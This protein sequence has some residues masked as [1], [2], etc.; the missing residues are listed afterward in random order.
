M[1]PC[2]KRVLTIFL[3]NQPT[4]SIPAHSYLE[5]LKTRGVF[6]GNYFGIRHPSEPNYVAAIAGSTFGIDDDGDYDLNERTLVDLLE[7][8]GITWKAYMEDLPSNQ[9]LIHKSGRYVRK[10]NP[11]ASFTTITAEPA[12]LARIVGADA[13]EADAASGQLPQYCWYTPNLDN[14]G[15]DTGITHASQWLDGFLTPLFAM[16]GFASDT[17]VV[18]TFDER[19]PDDDN[20]VYAVVVG[21]GAIPGRVDDTRYDHYSVL[22]T[23]EENWSLGTLG[24][25]DNNATWF[26]FLWGLPPTV[27]SWEDHNS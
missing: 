26:S 11:F 4:A 21:P 19:H 9:K 14:D 16:P 25:S 7:Q 22:R 6:L 18:V 2:F 15:H 24:R 1:E 20:H 23:V 10:H 27:T 12:R 13:F 8:H 17:L 5:T 3:E